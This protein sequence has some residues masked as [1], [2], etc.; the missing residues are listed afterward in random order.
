[1][2]LIGG[3]LACAC[4]ILVGWW[5]CRTAQNAI[6]T[7]KASG[8]HAILSNPGVSWPGWLTRSC[9]PLL[10]DA[11]LIDLKGVKLTP[12][13]MRAVGA[14]EPQELDLSS[15]D[16]TFELLHEIPAS[17]RLQRLWLT[18]TTT[19]DSML[20][21][22][23]QHFPNLVVLGLGRTQITNSGVQ[24]LAKLSQLAVVD[25]S[26]TAIT[27][28]A[29]E[30]L[31]AM[32]RVRTLILSNTKLGDAG[33]QQLTAL[34]SLEIL[35]VSGT[36]MTS[37]GVAAIAK[38][39]WLKKLNLSRTAIAGPCLGPL[40]RLTELRS[41][42]LDGTQAE[43]DTDAGLAG[44]EH[45]AHLSLSERAIGKAEIQDLQRCEPLQ[46]LDL[47]RCEI[48]DAEFAQLSRLPSLRLVSA[49]QTP[50]TDVSV[51]QVTRLCP[52]AMVRLGTA[53]AQNPIRIN[54][55]IGDTRAR[56][57][58]YY[59]VNPLLF[60]FE[61]WFGATPPLGTRPI[62]INRPSSERAYL[63]TRIKNEYSIWL[64]N[65]NAEFNVL[66]FVRQLSH[67]LG[68]VWLRPPQN[69]GFA[70]SICIALSFIGLEDS[71]KS[72]A[73]D[74][75]PQCRSFA[76]EFGHCADHLRT[77]ALVASG[78]TNNDEVGEWVI[79]MR[80]PLREPADAKQNMLCA[81]LVEQI[82][83]RHRGAWG[84]LTHVGSVLGEGDDH[85]RVDFKEW[86]SLVKPHEQPLVDDLAT[87]F[88]HLRLE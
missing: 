60:Q 52:K 13:V 18:K 20:E 2:K 79:T 17:P 15:G 68:H 86:R 30:S 71:G 39:G 45:L 49:R 58:V 26:G 83:N 22:V 88:A 43:F 56:F 64:G 85:W 51:E 57:T 66:E 38:I 16:L 77:L 81:I 33:I 65:L 4:L 10:T 70:E 14:L 37:D 46:S 55:S 78:L 5:H 63:D 9:S 6:D 61:Q 34:R 62:V 80:P 40:L 69:S 28:Q 24:Q 21:L 76:P 29:A 75:S 59:H 3:G 84:A 35:D 41:L 47:D 12:K 48:H 11:E 42:T 25:L 7:V 1:M 74:S 8:G 19:S 73:T 72:W 53:R 67:E 23:T 27:D 54:P 32:Q 87:A 36:S 82:L 44:F 31:G 50:L